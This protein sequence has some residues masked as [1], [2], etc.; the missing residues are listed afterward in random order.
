MRPLFSALGIAAI[1][2][3]GTGC[4]AHDETTT[5]PPPPD[6]CP[7]AEPGD[8]LPL[9]GGADCDPLVPTQCGF[10]FPSSVY[11][12]DDP[13]T[14]TGKR[15]GFGATTLPRYTG[16][17][18]VDRTLWEDSDGFSPGQPA[19]THLPGATATG[20]PSPDTIADS[21]LDGSPTVIIDAETGERIPH[22]AELDVSLIGE[23]DTDHTFLIRPAVRL[24]D[25]ARYIVAVRHVVDANGKP[26]PPSPAFA[27]LRDGTESCDLS[28]KAR[29]ALYDDIFAR[30]AKA[31]VDKSDLQIAWDYSTAS[32][33]NN[34]ARFVAMRDEALA[35]VGADGPPYT[36][37]TVEENPNPHIRRR[38]TGKMIVPLYLDKPGPG[39]RLVLGP[40][41]LPMQ[42]GT[43]AFDFVVHIPNS[44]TKGTPGRLL[45]NGH[46]LLG[47]K[48]E[49]Q[50]GY[51]AVIADTKNYVAFS[52]DLIG[53]ASEDFP[54]VSASLVGDIGGFKDEIDRQHQ[55][56]LNE[57]LAMRMMKGRF[58]KEP[59]TII[60]GNPTID[61]DNAH[62]RGD[63]QGGIFG[64]TYMA[65][66]TDVTRGLVSVPGMNYSLLLNRSADF[67]V[68]FALLHNSYQTGR[69]IQLMLGLVQMMWDRTEPNG[70]APYIVENTLPNTPSHE[71]ILHVGIGDYQVS[72]LGAHL[73]ARTVKAKSVKP[74]NRPI[75][76]VEEA[77]A[78]ITGSAI[79]EFSFGLP[80]APITDVPNHGPDGT[81]PHEKVRSLKAA[82]DQEDTFFRTGVV[83]QYCDGVC[84]PE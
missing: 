36:I 70:Y 50:D 21:L 62:Y 29:R 4:F 59:L 28:V 38:I 46:G 53:M 31:G 5:T 83:K 75:F 68:Y 49:G 15:V 1:A 12:H 64:T 9:L 74:A 19:I 22:F 8:G 24:R 78:P 58:A 79:T 81:D 61:P 30:L 55:G 84:D 56:I 23:E 25:A 54:T 32:R 66:S 71:I 67:G 16:G 76:G 33:E 82:I 6:K 39:A 42:N 34:T 11:L 41:G 17:A 13:A 52:V 60:D 45:Q 69:N 77:D 27:A 26:I 40:D 7:A 18:R 43:A 73:I 14:K 37:T 57:L 2:L 10:P 48:N 44:A 63:S 65:V 3:A 35:K 20:L 47:S 51:L 80:P 72:P